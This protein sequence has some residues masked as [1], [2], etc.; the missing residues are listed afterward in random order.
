MSRTEFPVNGARQ[1]AAAD[2]PRQYSPQMQSS[3]AYRHPRL[4]GAHE[5]ESYGPRRSHPAPYYALASGASA[6]VSSTYP[7]DL[8]R[9]HPLTSNLETVSASTNV[10]LQPRAVYAGYQGPGD[11][12]PEMDAAAL[13]RARPSF[14]VQMS[15]EAPRENVMI[16]PM[17]VP[18]ERPVDYARAYSD[19]SA[20]PENEYL[21][22]SNSQSLY[23]MGQVQAPAT[24]NY[25]EKKHC[26]PHCNKRCVFRSSSASIPS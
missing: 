8:L 6:P 25:D 12:S 11:R 17:H 21:A 3:Q 18:V 1:P 16:P 19:A 7:F 22:S 13:Q 15:P 23:R 10:A 5:P 24:P 9:P 14:R 20:Y 2:Y 4:E 26:C